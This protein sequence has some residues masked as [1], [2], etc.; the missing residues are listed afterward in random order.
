MIHVTDYRVTE[1]RLQVRELIWV[2]VDDLKQ[3]LL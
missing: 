1:L 2:H 3:I